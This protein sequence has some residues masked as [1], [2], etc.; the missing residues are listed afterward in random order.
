MLLNKFIHCESEHYI[1]LR[2]SSIYGKRCIL[3]IFA[4]FKVL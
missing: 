2:D 3:S 4:K 1:I